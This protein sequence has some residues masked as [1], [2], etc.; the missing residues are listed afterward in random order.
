MPFAP[1]RTLLRLR[2]HPPNSPSLTSGPDT[3]ALTAARRRGHRLDAA[4]GI[5]KDDPAAA[6]MILHERVLDLTVTFFDVRGEWTPPTKRRTGRIADLD[7]GLHGLLT[8][9]YADGASFEVQLALASADAPTH[10]RRHGYLTPGVA[11]SSD[12]TLASDEWGERVGCGRWR[13]C[14]R[15]GD[16]FRS[17]RGGSGKRF[18]GLLASPSRRAVTQS[19]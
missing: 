19:G 12:L 7:P 8:A 2:A 14:G 13:L 6:R 4:A 17:R 3:P 15:G 1:R 18:V 10:L 5:A 9:M 16:R 11:Q